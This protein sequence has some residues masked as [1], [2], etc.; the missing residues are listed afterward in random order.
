MSKTKKKSANAKIKESKSKKKLSATPKKKIIV[1]SKSKSA[2]KSASKKSKAAPGDQLIGTLK[3]IVATV[4][5]KADGVIAA[6]QGDI[7]SALKEDHDSMRQYLGTLK[8]TD[9]PMKERR[10]AYDLFSSLLKSHSDAE[11]NAVYKLSMQL[12]G[13]EM[14]IKISEG[15]VEH[16]LANDI[17]RRMDS[18]DDTM[19]WSAHANVL[20][21]IVD[22]HLKEEE[23]DLFPKIR[24]A[25]TLEQ[26]MEMLTEFMYLRGKTQK[27]AT[28]ENA[29]ALLEA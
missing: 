24:K 16:E 26:N 27:D 20:A 25:A 15:F 4:T 2:K 12:T 8:D 13:K 14:H 21:E 10:R 11:E 29:G 17:L 18:T 3:N 19:S 28:K 9:K 1:K 23:R 22:H 6:F 7:V 5:E